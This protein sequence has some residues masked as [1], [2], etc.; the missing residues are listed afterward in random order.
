MFG[1]GLCGCDVHHL[2]GKVE[3]G[4]MRLLELIIVWK[5]SEKV[6][7]LSRSSTLRT[8]SFPH[9]PH[10]YFIEKEMDKRKRISFCIHKYSQTFWRIWI[11]VYEN[12]MKENINAISGLVKM[13]LGTVDADVF[14]YSNQTWG[15]GFC[16]LWNWCYGCSFYEYIFN[17]FKNSIFTI[18]ITEIPSKSIN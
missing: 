7:I 16:W 4:S 9:D 3:N 11:N 1:V 5:Y 6:K 12:F 17:N 18:K 14:G 13:G 8:T 15:L 2:G 10:E